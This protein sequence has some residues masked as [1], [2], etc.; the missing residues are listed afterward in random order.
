MAVPL[1]EPSAETLRYRAETNELESQVGS[2]LDAMSPDKLNG[3]ISE[4]EKYAVRAVGRSGP[5]IRP[6]LLRR[7]ARAAH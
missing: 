4:S 3:L 2:L 7:I 6:V 5:I 1:Y